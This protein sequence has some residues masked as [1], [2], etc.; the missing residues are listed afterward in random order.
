MTDGAP[1]VFEAREATDTE[2]HAEQS[3]LGA[4]MTPW[5]PASRDGQPPSALSSPWIPAVRRVLAPHHFYAGRH[6]L[7]A[8]AVYAL[9]DDPDVRGIDQLMVADELERRGQLAKAGG[10]MYLHRCVTGTPTATNADYYADIV[11]AGANRRATHAYAQ[12]VAQA[13]ATPEPDGLADLVTSLHAGYLEAVSTTGNT[14]LPAVGNSSELVDQLIQGWGRPRPSSMTTG[15][16]DVD[17][18]LNVE[19]GALVVIAGRPGS[20][21]SI[22]GAQIAGHYVEERGEPAL[23]FSAE[24]SRQELME[25]DLARL[26]RVRLDSATGRTDLTAADAQRLLD[27][28][29]LYT[30]IGILLWYDDTP[31]LSTQHIDARFAEVSAAAGPPRLVAVD[32]LQLMQT[33][34]ADRR[35]LAIGEVSRRLKLFAKLHNIIVVLLCQLNRGPE[36]RPGGKPAI[37]DLRESGSIEQDADVVILIHDV[38]QYDESRLG[39]VDLILAKQRKGVH[40]VTIAVADQRPYAQF[41]DLPR[42]RADGA[43]DLDAMSADRNGDAWWTK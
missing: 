27:V 14:D 17:R 12:R 42:R 28:G 18:V 30:A 37:A 41:A 21:K 10:P 20:G 36:S 4:L 13:A 25:R 5:Y 19:D 26:A 22:L 24:M 6:Q 23:F 1:E 39:E 3:V 9:A 29:P 16:A 2:L 38:A 15:L 8:A 11:R 7:I 33:P 43:T 35:D 31:G 34:K 32:Y 40:G